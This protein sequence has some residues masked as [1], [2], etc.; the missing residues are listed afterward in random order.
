MPVVCPRDQCAYRA[1]QREDAA[2]QTEMKPGSFTA[3]PSKV[4]VARQP[5]R[6]LRASI[7]QSAKSA[8]ESF[9]DID[10]TLNRWLVLEGQ[11]G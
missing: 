8:A 10:G 3:L 6:R 7:R 1:Q 2:H 5:S 11:S 9:Q 4:A